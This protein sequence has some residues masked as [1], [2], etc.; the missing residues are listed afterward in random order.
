[1]ARWVPAHVR[2]GYEHTQRY[3]CSHVRRHV[4]SCR[5]VCRDARGRACGWACAN[6]RLSTRLD[7]HKSKMPH[8]EKLQIRARL[9]AVPC[10]MHADCAYV[11][12]SALWVVQTR[13]HVFNACH[14]H[15]HNIPAHMLHACC[16]GHP[17]GQLLARCMYVAV[18]IP[19]SCMIR[20]PP[21][22]NFSLSYGLSRAIK[23]SLYDDKYDNLMDN[24]VFTSIVYGQPVVWRLKIKLRQCKRELPST[25]AMTRVYACV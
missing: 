20:L 18:M 2:P 8:V 24:S 25:C 15:G 21:C 22:Y 1:M 16:R 4:L 23:T 19:S 6:M 7:V 17:A 10:I 13:A 3:E 11:A 5:H 14:M 12:C 9:Q